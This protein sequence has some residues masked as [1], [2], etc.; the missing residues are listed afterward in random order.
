VS[1]ATGVSKT[2]LHR[3]RQGGTHTKGPQNRTLK[4]LADYLGVKL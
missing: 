4:T 3:I 1:R 2:T